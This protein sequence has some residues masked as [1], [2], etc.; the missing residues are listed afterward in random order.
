MAGH[1]EQKEV[2]HTILYLDMEGAGL[3][4][5]WN[6]T[7][8]VETNPLKKMF[9]NLRLYHI[10]SLTTKTQVDSQVKKHSVHSF[11]LSY[12]VQLDLHQPFSEI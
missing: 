5:G 12:Q 4:G 7:A 9:V 2:E 6:M 1:R 10:K 8:G 3:V 11:T